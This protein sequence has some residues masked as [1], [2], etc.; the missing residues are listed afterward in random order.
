MDEDRR[1]AIRERAFALWEADGRPEGREMDYWLQAER[2]LA[3]RPAGAGREELLRQGVQDAV[4]D[5]E[6]L[7]GGAEENPLS[8]RVA[9]AT[10]ETDPKPGRSTFQGGDKVEG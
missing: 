6:R 4:P 3:D 5:A 8:Q 2:E 7:P 9:E 10:E 1:H